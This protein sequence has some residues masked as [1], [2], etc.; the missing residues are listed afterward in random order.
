[1]K[2]RGE[3]GSMPARMGSTSRPRANSE[4]AA[5]VVG[6]KSKTP[7]KKFVVS[8]KNKDGAIKINT[9]PSKKTIKKTKPTPKS[10]EGKQ[11]IKIRSN[12][13]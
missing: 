2:L 8:P 5:R 7:A 4:T 9:N 11:V 13:L 10:G 12:N 3:S 6:P 1:M